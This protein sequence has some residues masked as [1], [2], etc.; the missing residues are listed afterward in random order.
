MTAE[1]QKQRR[2]YYELNYGWKLKEDRE[3]CQARCY[4]CKNKD[5][6]MKGK[7]AKAER[8]RVAEK[9]EANRR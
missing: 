1:K 6:N 2:R 8:Q 5:W 4:K 9:A 3:I 7:K